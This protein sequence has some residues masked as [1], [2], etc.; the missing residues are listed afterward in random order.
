MGGHVQANLASVGAA[1]A[2]C[3]R[4]R[5]KECT[6]AVVV[7]NGVSSEVDNRRG[8]G[9]I[10]GIALVGGD[11]AVRS[12]KMRGSDRS[13]AGHGLIE[14]N[15]FVS[16]GLTVQTVIGIGERYAVKGNRICASMTTPS[17]LV[18]VSLALLTVM[19]AVE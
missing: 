18:A 16:L 15:V 17:E 19:S 10:D 8:I 13:V 2:P 1:V 14:E 11:G 4:F 7:D 9:H 3:R 5:A 6:C 12:S